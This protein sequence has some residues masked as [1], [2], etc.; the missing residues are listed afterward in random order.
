[1]AFLMQY[2]SVHFARHFTSTSLLCVLTRTT[3]LQLRIA[4]LP[5]QVLHCQVPRYAPRDRSGWHALEYLVYDAV[6]CGISL[7]GVLVLQSLDATC[8]TFSQ[9]TGASL[10]CKS[11]TPCQSTCASALTCGVTK[12][13]RCGSP[14]AVRKILMK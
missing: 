2:H 4:P 5:P 12:E 8:R 10:V 9:P 6:A 11:C 3:V 14:C 7:P 13:S 1:M